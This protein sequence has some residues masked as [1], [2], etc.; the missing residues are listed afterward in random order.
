MMRASITA[1][2]ATARA[3][4][5]DHRAS[6][7]VLALLAGGAVVLLAPL[8]AFFTPFEGGSTTLRFSSVP[9]FGHDLG[10]TG[11]ATTSAMTQ[12]V[13]VRQLFELLIASGLLM[14][15]VAA[16]SMLL[17]A[18]SIAGERA[19]ELA[20]R[21]AVGASRRA[22]VAAAL[23]E[24][25]IVGAV[26]LGGAALALALLMRDAAGS[27][28]GSAVEGG[29][30]PV[31]AAVA[32]AVVLGLAA[33]LPFMYRGRRR[34]SGAVVEPP[35]VLVPSIQ[36]GV[37]LAVLT[38]AGIVSDAA[39]R[40][41]NGGSS[42][43]PA[44]IALTLDAVPGPA[45]SRAE[46]YERLIGALGRLPG[47]KAVGVAS[48]GLLAGI[49][50]VDFIRTDCGIC[51][52]GG[53]MLPWLELYGTV[54][55]ASSDTFRAR[56][57]DIVAG[58]G[59]LPGDRTGAEPV[60]VV[61]RY[62]AAR[63]FENGDAVGR[64]IFVGAD[65]KRARH[66]VIGVVDDERSAAFGGRGLPL[67][68][69]YLSLLQHPPTAVEILLPGATAGAAGTAAAMVSG[70]L[71][72]AVTALDPAALLARE[73]APG[74]WFSRWF[75]LQG[76][77][78]LGA[79]VVG[80]VAFMRRW[81]FALAPEIALRRAVGATCGRMTLFVGLGAARVAV[82]GAAVG[83]LFIG[84]ALWSGVARNV[85]GASA[86]HPGLVARFAAVLILACLAAAAG[87][88]WQVLRRAPA[89]DLQAG[90]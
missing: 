70:A 13:A 39:G 77:G 56:G 64:D 24:A 17:V 89:R 57:V 5:R 54:Q 49:G 40:L 41:A 43:L 4:L 16:G 48:P 84:P 15:A 10:W 65:W 61:N 55:I 44:G 46:R 63:W 6:A 75:G 23:A 32:A 85:P 34:L 69:A 53:I 62:L 73:A 78:L 72:T 20:V 60:A 87:P 2:L 50:V 3:N 37:A 19:A 82:A 79:A 38:T 68:T 31:A 67:E 18:A 27:W 52:R 8:L 66:R 14:F 76:W 29:I 21:R 83:L 28:P 90:P 9:A 1:A 74:R 36:L 42:E 59:F 12:Q 7:H 58:R 81:V 51:V 80:L 11:A 22:L 86:W 33:L 71:G 25:T 47:V 45:A 30:G 26:A 88:A 35:G